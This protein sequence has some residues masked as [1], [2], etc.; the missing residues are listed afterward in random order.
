MEYAFLI[1][2]CRRKI[3]CQDE[4]YTHPEV[5]STFVKAKNY[6]DR[7]VQDISHRYP[8]AKINYKEN[9][10]IGFMSVSVSYDGGHQ[11]IQY[12][13]KTAGVV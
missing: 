13:I 9:N 8:D 5:Y 6:V 4:N 12:N 3:G 11:F 2:V 10:V 7:V 1:D